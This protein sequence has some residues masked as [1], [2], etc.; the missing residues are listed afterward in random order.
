V[1]DANPQAE[2]AMGFVLRN[3]EFALALF[4]P[5]NVAADHSSYYAIRASGGAEVVGIDG[6]TIRANSLGVDING[7]KDHAGLAQALDLA[8]S[9]SFTATGGVVVETG[10]DPDG[11]GSEPAPSVTLGYTGSLMRATGNVTLAIDNFVYVSGSFAF[12]KGANRTMTLVGGATKNVS[13]LTVGAS[14]VNAFVGTGNPDRNGDG[15]LDSISDMT[16]NGAI[17]L[18]IADL[19]FGLALFKPVSTTDT[20]SYYALKASAA[21]IS[22]V[23]V[24]GV[25]LTATTLSVT[26][27]GASQTSTGGATPTGPPP[28]VINF[29]GSG[30]YVATGPALA[31]RLFFDMG[32]RIIAAAGNV[33]IGL[34]FD[35]DSVAE[36]TLSSFISFE[37][38]FRPNGTSVI[39]L[40]MTNLSFVLGDPADPVFSL[41]GLSGYFLIT[42]QGMA[43]SIQYNQYADPAH[44]LHIYS[45]GADITLS[46]S[47]AVE[48][49]TTN[50]AVNETFVID[51]A[52]NDQDADDEQGTVPATGGFHRP[53]RRLCRCVCIAG[54]R[55][56]WQLRLRA[57][58]PHG[59]NQGR[60]YRGIRRHRHGAW[61]RP[62]Q[63]AGRLRLFLG[64]YRRTVA[65]DHQFRRY[66]RRYGRWRRPA[67]DQHHRRRGEPDHHGWQ[68]QYRHQVRC[69]RGPCGPLRN[70]QRHHFRAAVL[71]N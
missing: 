68:H 30:F 48:I 8:N 5:T 45:G 4:K 25:I 36:V 32:S 49:N 52:G 63:R 21:G 6:I 50:A 39:K 40:A 57:G 18:R 20:V 29:S 41:T 11:A 67:A 15:A 9:P 43:A 23:G 71:R 58:H 27:N 44:P 22:L 42:P 37:Q 65:R 2:G 66:R 7:G 51:G 10:A 70:S 59:R 1:I 56:A 3:V 62:D 26:V 64:R 69:D 38:S 24:P 35:T 19:D 54:I 47:L 12:E 17:G 61:R 13:V 33:S 55:A 46:G 14:N 53:Y 34:D 60:A 16:A 28:A 31:D